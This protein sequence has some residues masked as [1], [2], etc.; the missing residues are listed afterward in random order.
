M[1]SQENKI[2]RCGRVLRNR[3]V[4]REKSSRASV[5]SRFFLHNV[6]INPSKFQR[7]FS[8]LGLNETVTE[9]IPKNIEAFTCKLYG[10]KGSN[11]NEARTNIFENVY[12][13]KSEIDFNRKCTEVQFA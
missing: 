13:M 6:P 7:A 11:I 5:Y 10:N 8:Q 4:I 9:G 1:N 2:S 12:G 3:D